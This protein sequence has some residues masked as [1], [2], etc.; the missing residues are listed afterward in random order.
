[1]VLSAVFLFSVIGIYSMTYAATRPEEYHME[2]S[3]EVR[4]FEEGHDTI[5]LGKKL[6]AVGLIGFK[7][8]DDPMCGFS[9]TL[10]T[11][12]ELLKDLLP[13]P[14][15][16]LGRRSTLFYILGKEGL[17]SLER[18]YNHCR[19]FNGLPEVSEAGEYVKNDLL[20]SSQ[21]LAVLHS[22]WDQTAKGEKNTFLHFVS[23]VTGIDI[24]KCVT[25]VT[26]FCVN[27]LTEYDNDVV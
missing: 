12:E 26:A 10:R 25:P 21:H 16:A 14:K 22:F 15:E 11:D 20:L 9:V 5:I 1:M 2:E 8:Y 3:A 27:L 23:K 18:I 17:K 24:R 19:K 13:S 7:E 4:P 6:Y